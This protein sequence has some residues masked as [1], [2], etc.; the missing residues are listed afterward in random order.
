MSA[1][2][3]ALVLIGGLLFLLVKNL[4]FLFL[5]RDLLV[6]VVNRIEM[7]SINSSKLKNSRPLLDSFKRYNFD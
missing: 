6:H 2:T 7:P 5:I 1:V 3:F 4:S